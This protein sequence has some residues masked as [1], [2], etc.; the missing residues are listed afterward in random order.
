MPL[1]YFRH[2]QCALLACAGPLTWT[3]RE[4]SARKRASRWRETDR[5]R[6]RVFGPAWRAWSWRWWYTFCTGR[7]SAR[8]AYGVEHGECKRKKRAQARESPADDSDGYIGLA[9]LYLSLSGGPTHG[10][11]F[12]R[13]LQAN[14]R[15]PRLTRFVG[16]D[17]PLVEAGARHT[18]S[19]GVCLQRSRVQLASQVPAGRL[20]PDAWCG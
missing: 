12:S 7:A 14:V 3:M 1:A 15:A 13:S 6:A 10:I 5:G 19:L 11:H 17:K 4:R 8:R 9:R 18:S 16:P 2:V 20:L